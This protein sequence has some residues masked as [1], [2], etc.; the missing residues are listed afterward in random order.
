[1]N[2]RRRPRDQR[3]IFVYSYLLSFI[4]QSFA[5][6]LFK[7]LVVRERKLMGLVLEITQ[8]TTGYRVLRGR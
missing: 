7:S 1:M 8:D 5:N 3:L 2:Y 6:F 4:E